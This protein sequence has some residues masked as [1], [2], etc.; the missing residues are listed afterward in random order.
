MQWKLAPKARVAE[1]IHRAM[2]RGGFPLL[3]HVARLLPR[4]VLHANAGWVFAVIMAVYPG[5]KSRIDRNLARILD[6]PA[7]APAVRA[8]RR[9][10]LRNF[11]LSW[12]DLFHFAQRS[13]TALETHVAGVHGWHHVEAAHDAGRGAL[14]MT[15]H[16]GA[17]EVGGL[18][19]GRGDDGSTL[20]DL[21]VSVIY[22]PDRFAVAERF[23]SRLRRAGSQ[24]EEIPL[25]PGAPLASLP[26]LRAVRAGRLVALQGDRD[27]TER[28]PLLDF[29]GAPTPFPAGPFALARM[30]GAPLIPFY[31]LYDDHHRFTLR[32][33]APLMN[34][35][36]D[37]AATQ[38]PAAA[39]AARRRQPADDPAIRAAMQRWADQLGAQITAHPDQWYTF[40]DVWADAA[41]RAGDA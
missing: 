16:I 36:G 12:T 26:V 4:R 39:R 34:G 5:P 29:F 8:T 22:V 19:L 30:T 20:G 38:D 17:W 40:Y 6:L 35:P 15:A 27:F 25:T 2:L 14:L 11:A 21:P 37:P 13:L 7:D 28:G 3:L 33:D 32:F 24:L 31:V 10:M 18:L 23:R 41:R 1:R 9:R